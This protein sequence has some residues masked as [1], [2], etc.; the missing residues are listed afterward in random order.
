MPRKPAPPYGFVL[1]VLRESVGWTLEDLARETGVGFKALNKQERG[2]QRLEHKELEAYALAMG[3]SAE[4]VDVLL[5]CHRYLHP[6]K[7]EPGVP[8]ALTRE[9]QKA[10]A[11]EALE[12]GVAVASGYL[13][14]RTR[15]LQEEHIREAQQE[16]EELLAA[17]QGIS[18]SEWRLVFNE[19]EGVGSWALVVRLCAESEKAAAADARRALVL[20][21]LALYRA[22]REP[23][24]E[25]WRSRLTGYAW[26]FV[27]NARRVA[28]DLDGAEE[29]FARAW[30]FWH[31]GADSS[32]G[33]LDEA[34]LYDLEASLLCARRQFEAALA[35]H[36]EALARC[37]TSETEVSILLNKAFT[38]E[39]M[40]DVE[41]S[42][43][44]LQTAASRIDEQCRPRLLAVLR[45][46]LAVN[47]CHLGRFDEAQLLVPEVR[48]LAVQL[49]NG[50]DLVRVMWLQGKIAVGLGQ[51][52]EA[53]ASLEQV[54][55]EFAARNMLYDAA[56]V[57]LELALLYQQ[58]GR[59]TD[60]R[61]LVRRS[62]PIFRA[63]KVDRETM[64]AVLLF[65]QAAEKE[66]A[67]VDLVHGALEALQRARPAG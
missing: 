7:T 16:A 49:R 34:L 29:A 8:W 21:E 18:P 58:Q 56:L 38:L 5:V 46:N 40:G 67:T 3:Y 42:I 44:A 50:L 60:V 66:E 51:G 20:A 61:R 37:R 14:E 30:N 32:P 10:V 4:A 36:G 48:K 59:I 64:A 45:F 47:L 6:P 31:A 9:E 52:A 57:E 53:E 63:L 11:R 28:N 26:F 41:G 15:Q 62:A 54:R 35:R 25:G 43:L 19:A 17:F 65:C 1:K 27:A 55:Q 2:L 33:P 22:E 39:Q 12:L 23:G 13:E 24:A